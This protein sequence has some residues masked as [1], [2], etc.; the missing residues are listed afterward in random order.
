[1]QATDYF[2]QFSSRYRHYKGGS[3]CYED[4]CVYRGLQLLFQATGDGR[5]N[6][7][8]HRLADAQIAA[9]GTLAGY[10][11]Q[12]YNIDHILAGRILFPLAVETGDR[13]Y[14][15]AAQHLA[16]QLATHPRIAA[17]NYWHK[18]RYPHQVWLDG[19]YM[20]L[21]F[22]I[23]YAQ[24]T[25][26]AGLIDDALR[27]FSTALALTDDAGGLYVHGYDDSRSQRWADPQSGRSPAIWA[28][29]VGWLAMALVDALA[30]LPK[31]G[32]TAG[33][34][35]KT[36]SLLAGIIARQ[37]ET[38][39][40][41][42]VLDNPGLAS[43]YEETSASAMFAYALLHAVRLKLVQGEEANAALSAGRRALEA[44][45][46]TRLKADEKGVMRLTGI[47]HVA[48]L[49]GFEGNYRDGTPEYYLTEP[50]VSDDAK[51]VGPLMM[52]HAE[53]LLLAKPQAQAVSVA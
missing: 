27:Q 48:G 36:Q 46:E 37:T 15:A 43:N 18:K 50:V 25:G 32:A 19:L 2:H 17:G 9:D 28:R 30:I 3:W 4:G 40:W 21:P 20:G 47:V 23:E 7:Y 24:A 1:M 38:G 35:N 39:L 14:L 49:G 22:Q 51:G 5:W 41:M 8:L 53:S 13:R 45:L 34:R 16:G 6:D 26:H 11:P 10:D 33:L 12:E 52:A 31:D 29:A 44:L 42:Q